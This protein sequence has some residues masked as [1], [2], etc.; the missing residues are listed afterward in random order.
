M[1][2]KVN[3]V[4]VDKNYRIVITKEIRKSIPLKPKQ[5]VY[6][7]AAGKEIVIIPLPE[8]INEELDKLCGDITWNREVRENLE[9][10]LTSKM[11]REK[12]G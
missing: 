10:F 1:K 11:L 8:N 2:C 7:L 6:L 3:V 4:E 12:D 5:K 9:S